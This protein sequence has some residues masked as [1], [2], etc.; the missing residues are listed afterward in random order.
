MHLNVQKCASIPQ[1]HMTSFSNKA[2]NPLKDSTF[3][4]AYIIYIP[5]PTRGLPKDNRSHVD[6]CQDSWEEGRQSDLMG[7]SFVYTAVEYTISHKQRCAGV[8]MRRWFMT[9]PVDILF[10]YTI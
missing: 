6:I 5:Q 2:S 7:F 1:A 9:F 4:T 3:P 8:I 10:Y